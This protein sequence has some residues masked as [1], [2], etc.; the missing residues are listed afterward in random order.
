VLIGESRNCL[1]IRGEYR[2]KIRDD[3]RLAIWSGLGAHLNPGPEPECG[4][5][6]GLAMAGL[7]RIQGLSRPKALLVLMAVENWSKLATKKR[8]TLN[9]II[10]LSIPT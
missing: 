4:E 8:T 1:K 2:P 6:T 3:Y 7:A 5:I 10:E 9:P